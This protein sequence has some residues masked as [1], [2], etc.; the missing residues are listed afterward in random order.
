M[1]YLP[2]SG[3]TASPSRPCHC[4]QP[5]ADRLPPSRPPL[6]LSESGWLSWLRPRGPIARLNLLPYGAATCYR[7][8]AAAYLFGPPG[9]ATGC[10]LPGRLSLEASPCRWSDAVPTTGPPPHAPLGSPRGWPAFGGPLA[11]ACFCALSL[12]RRDCRTDRGPRCLGQQTVGYLGRGLT[13]RSSASA[14]RDSARCRPPAGPS[15]V[16][17]GRAS[18]APAGHPEARPPAQCRPWAARLSSFPR[19]TGRCGFELVPAGAQA[20]STLG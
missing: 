11:R 13:A 6:R 3:A 7:A 9:P 10:D 19:R 17:T 16:A 20:V 8:V 15:A 5:A 4:H 14:G 2:D 12:G 18:S 1:T